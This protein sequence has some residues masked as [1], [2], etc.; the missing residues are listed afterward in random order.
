MGIRNE[1]DAA[2]ARATEA[3]PSKTADKRCIEDAIELDAIEDDEVRQ[4]LRIP[5]RRKLPKHD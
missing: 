2:G 3:K 5:H 4:V 1:L